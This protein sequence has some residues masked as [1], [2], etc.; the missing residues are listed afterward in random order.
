M[1]K[2]NLLPKYIIERR[3]VKAWALGMVALLIIELVVLAA[4]VWSPLPPPLPRSLKQRTADANAEAVAQRA[5]AAKVEDLN[6]EIDAINGRFAAK[7]SWVT[8]KESADKVPERWVEYLTAVN[9]LIPADVVIH[10]LQVPSAGVLNLS[11]STSD[12]MAGV[13]WYLNVLRSELV[14]PGRQSVQFNPGQVAVAPVAGVTDPMQMSVGMTIVLKPEFYQEILMQPA[15]PA[16]LDG[17]GAS[18]GRGGGRMGGAPG[19][20]GRG[21]GRGGRG[22]GLGGGRGADGAAAVW[23]A[24]AGAAANRQK[25]HRAV[26]SRTRDSAPCCPGP[27]M[28]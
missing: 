17:G 19:A 16:D 2:L 5:A 24:E 4:Y 23:A 18:G 1:I 27:A 15:R 13:R 20:G 6:A 26:T 9:E 7:A 3:R 8:W 10:G 12:M 14:Q 21:G 25:A 11:A 28:R 22:G